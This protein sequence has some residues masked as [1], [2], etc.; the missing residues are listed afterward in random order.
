MC[1]VVS[2]DED[3]DKH[4][5]RSQHLPSTTA[6]TERSVIPTGPAAA[7][8]TATTAATSVVATATTAT[9]VASHLSQARVDLLL[10]LSEETDEITSLL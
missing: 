3:S 5:D 6:T 7:S 1:Q 8:T 2:V 10:G 4:D 9:A